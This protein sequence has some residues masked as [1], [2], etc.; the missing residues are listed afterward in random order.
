LA[1]VSADVLVATDHHSFREKML[2]THRGLSGPAI[3]QISSYWHPGKSIRI[4]F[5][6]GSDLPNPFVTPKFE[7]RQRPFCFA[8]VLAAAFGNAVARTARSCTWTNQRLASL[9]R[10]AHEWVFNLMVRKATRS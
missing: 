3:L 4:D 2:I 1:G 7:I 6:P 9:E 10:Q 5:A 8:E